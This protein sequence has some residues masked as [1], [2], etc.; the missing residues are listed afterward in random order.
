MLQKQLLEAASKCLREDG[1]IVY[2]TC[3][4]D[5]E[6]NEEVIDYAVKNLQ[7]KTEKIK[8]KGIECDEGM[9]SYKGYEY[10]ESVRKAVRINM[11]KNKT[12]G[13]FVCKL[14]KY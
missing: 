9:R 8:L 2:S 3:S 5:P 12:E 7:L 4:L 11:L 10:D 13:F 6:E 1:V 14:R